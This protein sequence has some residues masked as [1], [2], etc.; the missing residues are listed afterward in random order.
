[1]KSQSSNIKKTFILLIFVAILGCQKK[2]LDNS[3]IEIKPIKKHVQVSERL[4]KDSP[5]ILELV[6]KNQTKDF[7]WQKLI[8]ENAPLGPRVRQANGLVRIYAYC[9]HDEHES[10]TYVLINLDV[11]KEHIVNFN[12]PASVYALINGTPDL[13]EPTDLNLVVVESGKVNLAPRS[14]SFVQVKDTFNVCL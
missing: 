3:E 7:L 9:S 1:M 2:D 5:E 6:G 10:I 12:K 8:G 11:S 13:S 14:L 4:E